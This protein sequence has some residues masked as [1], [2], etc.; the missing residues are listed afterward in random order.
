MSKLQVIYC[1]IVLAALAWSNANGYV[2]ASFFT[3][4]GTANKNATHYHK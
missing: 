3:G 2:Y 1:A 4:Q